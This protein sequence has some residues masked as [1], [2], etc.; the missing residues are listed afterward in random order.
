MYRKPYVI[1]LL[2]LQLEEKN[3][4]HFSKKKFLP[5]LFLVYLRNND[6][7]SYLFYW[8]RHEDYG[9]GNHDIN[10]RRVVA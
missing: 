5:Q 6:Y 3:V 7:W 2:N 8:L 1:E 10:E 4:M 9:W